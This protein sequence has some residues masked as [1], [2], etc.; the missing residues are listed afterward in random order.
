MKKENKALKVLSKSTESRC[1]RN[2]ERSNRKVVSVESL[3]SKGYD[4]FKQLGVFLLEIIMM[5][6]MVHS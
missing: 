4:N 3:T 6:I 5:V 2:K 1:Y